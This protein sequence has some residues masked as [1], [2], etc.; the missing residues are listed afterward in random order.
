[1]LDQSF[2]TDSNPGLNVYKFEENVMTHLLLLNKSKVSVNFPYPLEDRIIFLLDG[3]IPI[4]D[5]TP[6]LE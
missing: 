4:D 1:M 6:H 5:T 2:V 3:L